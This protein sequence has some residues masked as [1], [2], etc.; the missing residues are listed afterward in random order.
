MHKTSMS[1]VRFS[2]LR[3]CQR[4]KVKIYESLLGSEITREKNYFSRTNENI[5]RRNEK[6]SRNNEKFS[7]TNEKNSRRNENFSR[8]NEKNSRMNEKL[9]RNN[10]KI[11]R[12][13]ENISRSNE[14]NSR[15]N[16][17]YSRSNEKNS[18]RNE[19]LSRRNE[20][21]SRTNE[22]ISRTNE[23][24]SRSNEKLSKQKKCDLCTSV[25]YVNRSLSLLN[26]IKL[27]LQ[28]KSIIII[29]R[30]Y[31]ASRMWYCNLRFTQRAPTT[32]ENYTAS[33]L[34]LLSMKD[35]V[36][37]IMDTL[38]MISSNLFITDS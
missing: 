15:R 14:K 12:R 35:F 1:M 2:V 31:K 10:E 8:N 34:I 5:S 26:R 25:N 33:F 30:Y 37:Q 13:N 24:S 11:S 4:K 23:K 27:S 29:V 19:K 20:K 16:E 9:S 22:N 32:K 28:Y 21:N 6:F 36:G 3:L 38:F 7:R 18:R 17:K